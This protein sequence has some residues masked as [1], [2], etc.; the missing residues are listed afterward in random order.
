MHYLSILCSR[1]LNL[2]A[3]SDVWLFTKQSFA[4]FNGLSHSISEAAYCKGVLEDQVKLSPGL[5]DEASEA[6]ANDVF[7]CIHSGTEKSLCFA[8]VPLVFDKH[9]AL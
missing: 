1:I 8:L 7:T 6:A 4:L 2:L 5:R 3:G 9:H